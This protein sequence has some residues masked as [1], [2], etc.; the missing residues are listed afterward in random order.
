[1]SAC[2]ALP[3]DVW[4]VLWSTLLLQAQFWTPNKLSHLFLCILP[5]QDLFWERQMD[6]YGM[7]QICSA[8]SAWSFMNLRWLLISWQAVNNSYFMYLG[9][10]ITSFVM[11]LIDGLHHLSREG[12]EIRGLA[13]MG[14]C[15]VI[16]GICA[17]CIMS[18]KGCLKINQVYS[19]ITHKFPVNRAGSASKGGVKQSKISDPFTTFLSHDCCSL[20]LSLDSYQILSSI[21]ITCLGTSTRILKLLSIS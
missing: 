19:S 7:S 6:V 17:R 3:V 4:P 15:F 13:G 12:W 2:S 1:M 14:V 20:S 9:N 16:F 10:V 11:L 5:G 21:D 18:P 8:P